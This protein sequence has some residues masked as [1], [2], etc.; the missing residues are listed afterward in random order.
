MSNENFI[1]E[2][3]SIIKGQTLDSGNRTAEEKKFIEELKEYVNQQNELTNS[4]NDLHDRLENLLDVLVEFAQFNFEMEIPIS[5]KA[6]ELDGI[7][8]GLQ[9][10]GQEIEF[11]QKEL[12]LTND[13]LKEAQSMAK[14]GSWEVII[15]TNDMKWSDEMYHIFDI[16]DVGKE[17]ETLVDM[18]SEEDKNQ[19]E[20]L[21]NRVVERVKNF[22]Y[23]F[24]A[25]VKGKVKYIDAQAKP[26]IV[27]QKVI[28][29]VGTAMDITDRIL[30]DIKMNKLNAELEEK[31]AERTKDLE[32]F[33]YSVSHDL[34][35]P[36]RSITGLSKILAENYSHLLDEEANRL[37][38][39]I[40]KNATKMSTLIEELLNFSRVGVQVPKFDEIET[41]ELV[42]SAWTDAMNNFESKD[43]VDFKSVE[44]PNIYGTK[45]MLNQV[46]AN[47]F[48][49]A[50]KYSSKKE[51]ISIEVGIESQ[52]DDLL[53]LFVRDNGC[54]FDMKYHDKL[55]GVFQRLHSED[56]FVGTGVG[57]AFVKRVIDKHHGK[58]WADSTLDEG[59]IFYISVPWRDPILF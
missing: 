27:N 43:I 18:I 51:K 21:F 57:L 19:L 35:A 47:L 2:L 31:V 20:D 33:S 36:L 5:D 6:D 50:L 37:L 41:N 8:L 53:T 4:Q 49:N 56:E 28:S 13:S 25:D 11:Y 52:D 30:A 40:I 39:I 34:R 59:S 14:I 22:N 16:P 38:T 7:A 3:H 29:V 26:I 10:L 55:F 32:G 58:I 54:G 24:L 45:S 42:T 48:S 44:L 9:T 46:F 17:V 15:E 1:S 12:V 23:V